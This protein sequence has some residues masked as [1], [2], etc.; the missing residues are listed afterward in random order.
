MAKGE[1]TWSSKNATVKKSNFEPVPPGDYELKLDAS[2][3]DVRKAQGEGKFPRVAVA[4]T[5]VGSAK[6]G[7]RD[8]L[9]FH[10]FYVRIQPNEKGNV[11][12]EMSGQIVAFAKALPAE[13]NVKTT[14]FNGE[15][16]LDPI[17]LKKWLQNRDGEIVKGRVRIEKDLNNEPRNR[18]ASFE[19]ADEA[20][21]E[22]EVD[23]EETDE[24][25]E[26]DTDE[27]EDEFEKAVSKKPAK[28]GKK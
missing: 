13:V 23:D 28:R 8:R 3:A 11:L 18:I 27:D 7:G 21:E 25:E 5:V 4:F 10:D 20:A 26:A 15:R 2:K 9:V 17:A 16:I 24:D 12:V 14:M 22:E 6:G 19:E 1:T